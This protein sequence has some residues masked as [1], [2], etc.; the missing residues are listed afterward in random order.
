VKKAIQ[1]RVPFGSCAVPLLLSL[2]VACGSR[3]PPSAASPAGRTTET[4]APTPA[5][6]PPP[7][8]VPPP[9]DPQVVERWQK[10]KEEADQKREER[11]HQR[12]VALVDRY[13]ALVNRWDSGVTAL[14]HAKVEWGDAQVAELLR[15]RQVA[16][17]L[18]EL[19]GSIPQGGISSADQRA[20]L[21]ALRQ[22]C[23]ALSKRFSSLQPQ[24]DRLAAVVEKREQ[25]ERAKRQPAI[26][27]RGR[28]YVLSKVPTPSTV[29]WIS[30]S[31]L[32]EC[33]GGAATQHEFDAQNGFGALSRSNRWVVFNVKTGRFFD[34]TGFAGMP[35]C[36]NP[37]LQ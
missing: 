20:R 8:L 33:P 30:D 32:A 14:E 21:D 4:A 26:I 13:E 9:S 2:S 18:K 37:L 16:D 10:Q 24:I 12:Q 1:V 22:R 31:V 7:P 36:E 35:T 27:Q 28:Q 25:A 11:E 17:E 29:R 15:I 19:G 34:I 6:E 5:P 3:P 23:D